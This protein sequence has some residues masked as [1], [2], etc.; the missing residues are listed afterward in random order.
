[1]LKGGENMTK[2]K[3]VISSYPGH[4]RSSVADVIRLGNI[5]CI[6]G[7][8]QTQQDKGKGRAFEAGIKA[9]KD[10]T[11]TIARPAPIK[12]ETTTF[13]PD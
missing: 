12:Q 1:M 2:Y 5:A 13:D 9:K 7:K 10:L 3:I 6:P 8:F 4:E 11:A